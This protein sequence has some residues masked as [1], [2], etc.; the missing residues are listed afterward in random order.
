MWKQFFDLVRQVFSLT[1][2]FCCEP[3]YAFIDDVMSLPERMP[4][5]YRRLIT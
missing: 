2:D 4:G 1:E 5:I 3:D